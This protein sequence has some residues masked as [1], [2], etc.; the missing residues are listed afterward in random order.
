MK[1]YQHR[2]TETRYAKSGVQGAWVVA[3]VRRGC[4]NVDC[5]LMDEGGEEDVP[6]C[7]TAKLEIRGRWHSSPQPGYLRYGDSMWEMCGLSSGCVGTEEEHA[8][9]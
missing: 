9:A 4:W 6:D 7:L 3:G 1:S 8:N 2:E 5:G